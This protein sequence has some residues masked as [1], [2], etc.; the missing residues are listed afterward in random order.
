M[1]RTYRYGWPPRPASYLQEFWDD[2]RRTI[3][4]DGVRLVQADVG[5]A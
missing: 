5:V 2:G 3:E 1:A 4:E